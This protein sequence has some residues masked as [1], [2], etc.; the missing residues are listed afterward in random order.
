MPAAIPS[1][2]Q[3]RSESRSRERGSTEVMP[4][5]S[6]PRSRAIDLIC[7]L[8]ST[9]AS[10]RSGGINVKLVPQT[11]QS[12]EP[13][14]LDSPRYNSSAPPR[15]SLVITFACSCREG[16]G[17]SMS[18]ARCECVNEVSLNAALS[19][20]GGTPLRSTVAPT[21]SKNSNSVVSTIRLQPTGSNRQSAIG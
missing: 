9:R 15:S 10:Y 13:R 6:N 7:D 19:P 17:V 14:R 12:A 18:A 21:R 4:A 1:S 5:T 20:I 2:H 8:S 11:V 16:I 3:A